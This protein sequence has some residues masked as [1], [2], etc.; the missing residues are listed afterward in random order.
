M[1]IFT[2]S[3]RRSAQTFG[4]RCVMVTC[5]THGEG[6][7][8]RGVRRSRWGGGRGRENKTPRRGEGRKVVSYS[9]VS[10]QEPLVLFTGA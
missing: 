4:L 6:V 2:P 3:I 10:S 7:G 1:Q 9:R 8:G 5:L